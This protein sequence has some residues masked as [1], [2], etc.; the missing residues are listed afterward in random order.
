MLASC[1]AIQSIAVPS[2]S[3]RICSTRGSVSGSASTRRAASRICSSVS[4]WADLPDNSVTALVNRAVVK[5]REDAGTSSS[6]CTADSRSPST[7]CARARPKPAEMMLL[8]VC[9]TVW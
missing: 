1:S 3:A 6:V 2:T 8:S 4:S 5:C 7:D 9:H